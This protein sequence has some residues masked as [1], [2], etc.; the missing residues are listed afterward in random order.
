MRLYALSS[1]DPARVIKL[2]SLP[3]YRK[4]VKQYGDL[5][6]T[7]SPRF[8]EAFLNGRIRNG[9]KYV[10][11]FNQ[12][13]PMLA[14]VMSDFV[15]S[16]QGIVSDKVFLGI[17][18]EAIK[19]NLSPHDFITLV[20]PARLKEINRS[21][22]KRMGI[23][24]LKR[25]KEYQKLVQQIRNLGHSE[26]APLRIK[27]TL[28]IKNPKGGTP[29]YIYRETTPGHFTG[30]MYPGHRAGIRQVFQ[31]DI[32]HM[33]HHAVDPAVNITW[34]PDGEMERV[35]WYEATT[36]EMLIQHSLVTPERWIHQVGEEVTDQ[37][38]G[39]RKVGH[40][41][42]AYANA[43]ELNAN[44]RAFNRVVGEDGPMSIDSHFYYSAPLKGENPLALSSQRTIDR[45]AD[46]FGWPVEAGMF[47]KFMI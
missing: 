47:I 9:A 21:A 11:L 13:D 30:Q 2:R 20:T 24:S 41:T 16:N 38:F 15:L 39:M 29:E 44:I 1:Y 19:K 12:A 17:I 25:N 45:L 33:P 40:R 46:G 10:K 4:L 18:D 23:E 37:F 7:L 14:R 28:K 22:V 34:R 8:A 26:S 36:D 43:E 27:T 32:P 3:G 31:F 42:Y 6:T 5:V 35:L